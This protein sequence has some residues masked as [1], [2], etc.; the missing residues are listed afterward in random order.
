MKAF[1]LLV[2]RCQLPDDR[3]TDKRK[4]LALVAE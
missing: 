3:L 4:A 1:I 2:D